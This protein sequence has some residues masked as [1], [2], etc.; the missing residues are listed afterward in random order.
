MLYWLIKLIEYELN[1]IIEIKP[2]KYRI[3]SSK[4]N[5]FFFLEF[6]LK[7]YLISYENLYNSLKKSTLNNKLIKKIFIYNIF[8]NIL[9]KFYIDFSNL[10]LLINNYK[11]IKIN[12]LLELIN[13]DLIIKKYN[14]IEKIEYY[15]ISKNDNNKYLFDEFSFDEN[16][17]YFYQLI[18]EKLEEFLNETKSNGVCIYNFRYYNYIDDSK[19]RSYLEEM[20]DYF[21]ELKIIDYV[22]IIPNKNKNK[23]LIDFIIGLKPNKINNLKEILK[24]KNLI[25]IKEYSIYK[26]LEKIIKIMNNRY[27]KDNIKFME[28]NRKTINT[29]IYLYNI[30]FENIFYEMMDSLIHINEYGW[31]IHLNIIKTKNYPEEIINKLE[32]KKKLIEENNK[33]KNLKN[34]NNI[35]NFLFILIIILL[36]IIIK[37]IIFCMNSTKNIN[38][39]FEIIKISNESN[40]KIF[41]YIDQQS[42]INYINILKQCVENEETIK[43]NINSFDYSNIYINQYMKY[44]NSI[45]NHYFIQLNTYNW[46][47]SLRII[48]ILTH[49]NKSIKVDELGN[50]DFYGENL[51]QYIST[52]SILI[53]KKILNFKKV[54]EFKEYNFIKM[55][56]EKII[57]LFKKDIN[58]LH[59]I[60]KKN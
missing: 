39:M 14:E 19:L 15:K 42:R 43:F 8:K 4:L 25:F 57:E 7:P 18:K 56:N 48:K 53:D 46:A 28:N 59:D 22:L 54:N 26:A 55:Y 60:Y 13:L 9:I 17:I 38:E 12:K 40:I 27:T 45:F 41:K 47:D 37:P 52:D 20:I 50:I 29:K 5:S 51:K 31:N 16:N 32:I 3:N 35:N 34:T 10:C 24:K 21:F 6:F 30:N 23:I 33:I 44:K 11:Y 2:K 49:S 1:F 58:K 36:L